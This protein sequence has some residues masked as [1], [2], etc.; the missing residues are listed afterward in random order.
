MVMDEYKTLQ[1]IFKQLTEKCSSLLKEL[2][3]EKHIDYHAI[4]FRTKDPKSFAKKMDNIKYSNPL[5]EITDLAGIRIIAYVEDDVSKICD[6]IRENFTIDLTNSLNK[7]DDLGIDKVGYRSIH[8]VCSISKARA[9]L[10]EYTKFADLKF[11]LHV[12]TI[13]QHSWAE[14]EHD[15]D[16]KFTWEL[17]NE[18]KRRFKLA[19]GT[20]EL[21]DRE[22]NQLS[23]EIDLYAKDVRNKTERDELDI[24][25]NSTSLKQFLTTKYEKEI[26]NNLITPNFHDSDGES[27]V[28]E[29]LRDFGIRTLN[30]L[31]KI[32]PPNYSEVIDSLECIGSNFL[33]LTRDAMIIHDH[34][35]Y[36]NQSY[37]GNWRGMNKKDYQLLEHYGVNVTAIQE[38]LDDFVSI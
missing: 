1:P 30:D 11:E 14:I 9:Q 2:L 16:Y 8:F 29:E 34:K 37:K 15:K 38:E 19:A 25:I 22:F 20:L 24:E 3:E 4:T 28:I 5:K 36:F 17:P 12:R 31:N 27:W 21:I 33:G 26:A 32:L 13:L 18:I 6:V 35:K 10:P 7:G 23:R